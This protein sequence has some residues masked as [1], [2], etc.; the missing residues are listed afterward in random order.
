MFFFFFLFKEEGKGVVRRGEAMS[1]TVLVEPCLVVWS[2]SGFFYTMHQLPTDL[3]QNTL[4]LR[5]L[6]S[7]IRSNL[8][9]VTRPGMESVVLFLA[10]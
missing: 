9:K 8:N 7:C 6:G 1:R 3:D 2:W 4:Q 10:W 5:K